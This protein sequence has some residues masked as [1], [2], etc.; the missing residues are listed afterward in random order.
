MTASG[1]RHEALL[2][3]IHAPL[4]RAAGYDDAFLEIAQ[5][6]PAGGPRGAA[7]H[8]RALALSFKKAIY[9][10]QCKGQK[11]ACQGLPR[12]E[13]PLPE[14]QGKRV[15]LVKC[16]ACE[17]QGRLLAAGAAADSDATCKRCP[18]CGKGE[19]GPAFAPSSIFG[20]DPCGGAGRPIPGVAV[21]CGGCLG[22][23]GLVMP[24]SE[25]SKTLQ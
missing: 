9:C 16:R 19:K 25:P 12:R 23:G 21:P 22:L 13:G 20:T 6:P 1:A 18:A 2:A 15:S 10:I 7:E 24:A 4:E 3:D 5:I 11:V 17:G 8:L 14:V